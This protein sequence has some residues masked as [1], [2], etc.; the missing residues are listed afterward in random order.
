[1]KSVFAVVFTPEAPVDL[2]CAPMFTVPL[3]DGREVIALNC[4]EFQETSMGMFRLVPKEDGDKPPVA[5]YVRPEHVLFAMQGERLFQFGFVPM[6]QPERAPV[7]QEMRLTPEGD[8]GEG[9]SLS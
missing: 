3:Q 2:F 8:S 9:E 6:P 1:M 4:T 5:L 7:Q